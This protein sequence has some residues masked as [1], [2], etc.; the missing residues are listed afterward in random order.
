[1]WKMGDNHQL[2][3]PEAAR[4]DRQSLELVR[5]WL[6]GEQQHVSIRGGVWDDPAAWGIMLAD[7]ARHV[8]N[9]YQDKGFDRTKTLRRIQAA[10]DAE[11]TSPTDEPSGQTF[12]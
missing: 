4:K 6:A 12:R 1:M 10:L 9:S 5:V 3:I 11:L 7:L 2:S 8:A